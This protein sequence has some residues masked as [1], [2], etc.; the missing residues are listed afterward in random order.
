L[1]GNF[2]FSLV[3]FFHFFGFLLFSL[4]L[5]LFTR[6]DHPPLRSARFKRRSILPNGASDS[7][8]PAFPFQR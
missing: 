8:E 2:L 5:N 1:G 4:S 3:F 7:H 6:I